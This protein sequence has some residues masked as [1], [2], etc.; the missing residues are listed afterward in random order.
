MTRN[1][2][3][4]QVEEALDDERGRESALAERLEEVVAEA[5]GPRIDEQVF[6][7]LEG[8]D[9]AL[10]REALQLEHGVDVQDNDAGDEAT[11]EAGWTEEEIARLQEEL[12]DSR[13]RQLALE[14][15]LDAL[16]A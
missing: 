14:R 7:R 3:R 11:D 9:A 12:A 1:Q 4:R 2:R 5:E 13:R 8:E 6:Q 16:G 10:V 15:Y